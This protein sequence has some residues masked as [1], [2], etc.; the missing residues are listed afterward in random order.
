MDQLHATIPSQATQGA[1]MG[2]FP[3]ARQLTETAIEEVLN[4]NKSPEQALDNAAME[5][6]LKIQE[7]NQTVSK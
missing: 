6:T 4:N 3:E 7:Y 2:V 5:I 1:V